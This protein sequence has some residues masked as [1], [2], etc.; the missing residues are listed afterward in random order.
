M[1]PIQLQLLCFELGGCPSFCRELT[2]SL[3]HHWSQ[4]GAAG[5]IAA[6]ESFDIKSKVFLQEVKG[7]SLTHPQSVLFMGHVVDIVF[8]VISTVKLC[9]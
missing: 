4:A 2:C 1:H 3:S 5:G 8:E 6:A 9:A 7:E